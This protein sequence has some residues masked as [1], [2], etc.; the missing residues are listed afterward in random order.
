MTSE[1]GETPPGPADA[2]P[3]ID[4]EWARRLMPLHREAG[5]HRSRNAADTGQ[6]AQPGLLDPGVP[7]VKGEGVK[8]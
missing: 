5:P 8:R 7:P 3:A 4:A 6:W 1:N 2:T